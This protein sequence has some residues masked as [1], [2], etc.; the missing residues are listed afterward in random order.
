MITTEGSGATI[1]LVEDSATQSV[2]L[3]FLLTG[4]GYQVVTAGDGQQGLAAVRQQRPALI[5]SDI[6]MPLMNGYEMCLQL[7]EDPEFADI[8]VILLTSLATL[9]DIVLGIEAKADYYVT[10][11]YDDDYL[12]AKVGAVLDRQRALVSAADQDKLAIQVEGKEHLISA[13]PR[14]ILN[15]LLSTYENALQQNRY[16]IK[17]QK[18]LKI[19]YEELE[20]KLNEIRNSEERY[21][22]L[23]RTIPD[24]V[25]KIDDNGNFLFLNDAVRYLA[26][27][28]KELV[29]RHFSAIIQSFKEVSREHVLPKY[30]GE[31]TEADKSPKL[32]DERRTGERMTTGLEVRLAMKGKG[33]ATHGLLE[34][35]SGESVVV[36]LN[37]CGLYEFNNHGRQKIF[38]GTVGVIRDITQRKKTELAVLKMSTINSAV[39]HLAELFISCPESSFFNISGVVLEQACLLTGSEYGYVSEID[40]V[41]GDSIVRALTSSLA[42]LC[43]I[44]QEEGGSF[45]K[46]KEGYPGLWGH[47][48]NVKKGF[49]TNAARR[50]PSFNEICPEG[51]MPLDHFLSVPAMTGNT[52][53]GQITLITSEH[54]YSEQDLEVIKRLADLYVL[55]IQRF[56]WSNELVAAK[57]AADEANRAKSDFLANM[58]HEIRTPLNAVTGMTYL[59]LNTELSPKQR[60][61]LNKIQASSQ[62][63]LGIINDILDFS[64]VEAG[65]LKMECVD[66]DLEELL[67]EIANMTSLK[68]EEKGVELILSIDPE[69]PLGLKGD[70]L[71]LGQVLNNLSNN[72]AKFTEKGEIVLSTELVEEEEEQVRLRF[73]VHDSGIGMKEEEL[74]SLFQ[75]FSQ[76][77]TSVTRKYGGSGLGLSISKRLVE[78]MGGTIHAESREGYGSSFT[79][80]VNFDRAEAEMKK[81]YLPPPD[82]RGLRVLVVDDSE[83]ARQSLSSQLQAWSYEVS[84][85]CSGEEALAKLA[86]AADRPYELVFMD[87]KMPGMD[88]IATAQ[89]IMATYAPARRPHIIMV[90]AFGREELIR[91][92]REAALD[93][94]LHK[95]VTPSTLYDAILNV[96]G[97]KVEQRQLKATVMP[98][99][100]KD[101][102]GARVLLVEDNEINQ[103]VARELL[104]TAGVVVDVVNNGIEATEAVCN[105]DYELVFMDIQMP[106]MDGIEAT[107]QI[108]KLDSEKRNVPIVAMTAH[109]LSGDREKSLLAGMNDHVTKPIAPA[110]LFEALK[111]W[112][113]PGE[114]PGPGEREAGGEELPVRL[115]A[116]LPGIEV[117]AGLR[118]VAGNAQLYVRL[119]KKF[120]SS[121]G[122]IGP[123][124]REAMAKGALEQARILAHTLKGVSGTIGAMG[125]FEAARV[126]DQA[127]KA[128]EVAQATEFLAQLE[129]ELTTVLG[130]IAALASEEPTPAEM[131]TSVDPEVVRPSLQRLRELLEENDTAAQRAF[132]ELKELLIRTALARE[133][134]RLEQSVEQYDF[135]NSLTIV[136]DIAEALN[137]SLEG[138]KDE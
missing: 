136:D 2:K 19:L 95:P 40:P 63:L 70:P 88:G 96:F 94:F 55:A 126:V 68:T 112:I 24:I 98:T 81:V 62:T 85:A 100:L 12:L 135:G 49:Y 89:E 20:E 14:Q 46:K 118:R 23:V 32:F 130:G 43:R 133:L 77:D 45:S 11:P 28:P 7:K 33:E 35:L 117:D 72:A 105:N 61:Y 27:E 120:Y 121:Q 29:G 21:E 15:L 124:I 110:K 71:R 53:V 104:V 64:K 74:S 79:F 82:L 26:Y 87:W 73:C 116:E 65:K 108:R 69:V 125:L 36:E 51:N 132:A 3:E 66:F 78:M 57:A 131:P 25:Y 113:K 93:V 22:S 39:A 138:K 42:E 92:S 86:E 54:E 102:Q 111:E 13:H 67:N 38:V 91:Q 101:I 50:H 60:D 31:K 6:L 114:R 52:L 127:L 9:K 48:L 41:S 90:S 75:A 134:E 119:L 47:A 122:A 83:T 128:G 37:S 30:A 84:P 137:V 5:I 109:A 1:L 4:V 58:S 97:R 106:E 107:R 18:E 115:P 17:A 56:R 99:D 123:A 59:A 103:Q 34:P 80:T 10:K 8:P 76:A 129:G 16:L 44:P